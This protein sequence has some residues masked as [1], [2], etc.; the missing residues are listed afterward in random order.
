[1]SAFNIEVPGGK[2]VRLPTAGKYCDRDIVVTSLVDEGTYNDGYVN[3]VQ[4]E[5]VRF[6][7]GYQDNGNRTDYSRAF[8]GKGWTDETSQGR[9]RDCR[10]RHDPFQ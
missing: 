10:Y 7:S 1:M 6:W 5:H 3:G 2:S 4:A 9:C 8:S